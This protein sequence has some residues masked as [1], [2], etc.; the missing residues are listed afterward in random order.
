M[1]NSHGTPSVMLHPLFGDSAVLQRDQPLPIWGVARPGATVT[2]RFAG[3]TA[4]TTAGSDGHW[5]VQ[6]EPLPAGG[7]H[8]IEAK[9]GRAAPAVS[10]DVL[11]GDVFLCSG[12]SN[13][14]WPLRD[15]ANGPA[16]AAAASDTGMRVLT[17]PRRV[18]VT[19][20]RDLDSRW[21]RCEPGAVAMFSA[22]AFHGGRA[23]RRAYPDI[24][25]GMIAAAWGGTRI[26][27]WISPLGLQAFPDLYQGYHTAAS[28][29]EAARRDPAAYERQVRAIRAPFTETFN[30]WH[31]E[32]CR[33]DGGETAGLMAASHPIEPWPL[34]DVPGH[35]PDPQIGNHAGIVWFACNVDVPAS[36]AGT[37]A[38][39]HLGEVD[40]E[41]TTWWNGEPI[42]AISALDGPDHWCMQRNHPVPGRLLHAGR[43]RLV[44]RVIDYGGRGGFGGGPNGL[45]L[46]KP[47]GETIPLPTQ[48]H[49]K[50]GSRLIEPCPVYPAGWTGGPNQSDP[51]A[52]FNGMISPLVPLAL[53]GIWWYQGE[54]NTGNAMAYRDLKRALIQDWRR[55]FRPGPATNL[56]P[57]HW[58]QLAGFTQPVAE[59]GPS[60]WA[61]LREAQTLAMALPATGQAVI[62]DCSD[63]MD[64]HPKNK[65]DPGE[66]LA[67][68]LRQ[69]RGEDIPVAGP[70]FVKMKVE[71]NSARLKFVCRGTLTTSD[72]HPPA[73]VAISG[74]DRQWRWAE[75]GLDGDSI[76]V[77]H[78]AISEPV[79]VRY[80]WADH[81]ASANLTDTTGL[82]A[83][84]F[85]TDDW[86]D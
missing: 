23:L 85:R 17:V 74:A 76:V 50:V 31:A 81:P 28:A 6:F 12:Q 53:A 66:R 68:W 55:L 63:A 42:G 8:T 75:S 56:L 22:V 45:C 86:P 13:M 5:L 35:W 73:H 30:R 11:I 61:L 70:R 48:W 59:P 26:E 84:P 20:L 69:A 57:F 52:L 83:W 77:S 58:V 67:A 37:D 14:E 34:H 27:P 24:P 29:A 47:E 80:A 43:N 82:P 7:P 72:G 41:D 40:N 79:A 38:V 65:R 9:A 2:V 51:G 10:H 21:N 62:L 44:V 49:F 16:E 15:S 25:V 3:R 1:K 60:S 64:V 39:L 32:L 54:S 71:G 18:S 78:P 46:R 36:W 4:V 33:S 19:P